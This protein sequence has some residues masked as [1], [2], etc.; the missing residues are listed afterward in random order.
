MCWFSSIC[1]VLGFRTSTGS[2]HMKFAS[3]SSEV[4][5]SCFSKMPP[6]SFRISCFAVRLRTTD[7]HFRGFFQ[8]GST[9]TNSEA[10]RLR[11]ASLS[12]TEAT[13][14]TEVNRLCE[15]QRPSF[16]QKLSR[17]R[18]RTLRWN[19]GPC[20]AS[21]RLAAFFS[22]SSAAFS[23]GT[24]DAEAPL[25]RTSFSASFSVFFRCCFFSPFLTEVFFFCVCFDR[26][27]ARGS[28]FSRSCNRDMLCRR[29]RTADFHFWP[30]V[31][32]AILTSSFS[33]RLL[34]FFCWTSGLAES[35]FAQACF[36]L[37]FKKWNGKG[38][39]WKRKDQEQS[40]MERW[41]ANV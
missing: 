30:R 18:T 37:G 13:V 21:G 20:S 39:E 22:G 32:L 19:R 23:E 14:Q 31:L 10:C 40:E 26:R 25:L 3:S 35:C 29:S 34:F 1:G 4:G 15:V 6:P 27:L 28:C 16:P 41:L 33:T 36:C 11:V 8:S 12:P 17:L 9:I 24:D 7:F 38:H 5:S 2:A